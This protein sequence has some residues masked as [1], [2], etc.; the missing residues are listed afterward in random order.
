MFRHEVPF[1]HRLQRHEG[2]CRFPH[3][4][5]YLFEIA[6]RGPV[7]PESGMVI[8]FSDLK[9][10]VRD[11]F[12]QFDHAFVLEESDPLREGLRLQPIPTKVVVLNVPPTAENLAALVREH[13]RTEGLYTQ[14]TCWEQR[15]CSA[16]ASTPDSNALPKIVEV[17]P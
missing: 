16:T 13:M 4:H 3:G 6:V 1:G 7:D 9:R 15:D 11:F 10:L 5:G 8:D 2:K 12:E 14:V 17:W